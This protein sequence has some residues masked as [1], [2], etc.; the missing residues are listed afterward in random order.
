MDSMMHEAI[1]NGRLVDHAMLRIKDVEA[2]IWSMPI[3]SALKVVMQ[4]KNM[5]LEMAL[6][7]PHIGFGTLPAS[8]FT[9]GGKKIIQCNNFSKYVPH[10]RSASIPD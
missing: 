6:E 2:M 5:I 3:R 4:V 8:E 7:L 10:I 9:P 1:T